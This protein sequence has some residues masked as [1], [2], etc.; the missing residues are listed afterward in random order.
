MIFMQHLCTA[1]EMVLGSLLFLESV[2]EGFCSTVTHRSGFLLLTTC[3]HVYSMYVTVFCSCSP[4][5]GLGRGHGHGPPSTRVYLIVFL[6]RCGSA[7][8]CT[9]DYGRGEIRSS[10]VSL[11]EHARGLLLYDL[12]CATP[13]PVP[14]LTSQLQEWE[15]RQFSKRDGIWIDAGSGINC[16]EAVARAVTRGKHASRDSTWSSADLCSSQGQR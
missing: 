7:G 15:R 5:F 4:A 3:S 8:I 16:T 13:S 14:F 11:V 1:P 6:R 9:Q 2:D 10:L 12:C